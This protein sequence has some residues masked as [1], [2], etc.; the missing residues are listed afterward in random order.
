ME[1]VRIICSDNGV[2]FDNQFKEYVFDM[3]KKINIGTEGIGMGLALIKKIV[4]NHG[5]TVTVESRH[6]EGTQ[7][8]M[9]LPLRMGQS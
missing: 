2:G 5:G 6:G 3:I 1:H 7:F 9:V 8:T 4:S